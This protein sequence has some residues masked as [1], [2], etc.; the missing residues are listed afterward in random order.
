MTTFNTFKELFTD[1][2]PYAGIQDIHH[3][4][5]RISRYC[6]L[7]SVTGGHIPALTVMPSPALL[8]AIAD[9]MLAIDR[10]SIYFHIVIHED[11]QAV[12]YAKYNLIIGSRKF[13]TI[14][15]SEIP[16]EGK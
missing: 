7:T 4:G 3:R 13:A 2:Q 16:L 9:N 8:D 1:S 12:V 10:D 5:F 15:A 6:M 14:P 11:G